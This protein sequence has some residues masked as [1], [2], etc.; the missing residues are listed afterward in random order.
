M[1]EPVMKDVVAMPVRAAWDLVVKIVMKVNLVFC[2]STCFKP[3]V[4]TDI[5]THFKFFEISSQ[6]CFL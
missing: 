2:S 3:D 1:E 4:K 5:I 6:V